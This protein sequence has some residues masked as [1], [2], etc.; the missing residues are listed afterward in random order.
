VSTRMSH[1]G[2][3]VGWKREDGGAKEEVRGRPSGTYPWVTAGMI[4]WRKANLGTFDGSATYSLTTSVT[5][6]PLRAVEVELNKMEAMIE[7]AMTFCASP[8]GAC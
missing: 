1:E 5:R 3:H 2:L 6:P 7:R 8:I 4:T